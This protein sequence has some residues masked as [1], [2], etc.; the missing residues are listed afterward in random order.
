MKKLFSLF[1]IGFTVFAFA[2]ESS[3]A[4]FIGFGVA[5]NGGFN[6]ELGQKKQNS[7][8]FLR[9]PKGYRLIEVSLQTDE[10]VD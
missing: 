4:Y 8:G 1:L 9:A 2:Q 6:F 3:P 10:L 5:K 7:F